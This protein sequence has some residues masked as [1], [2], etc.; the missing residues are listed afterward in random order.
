[1]EDISNLNILP[2]ISFMQF[3]PCLVYLELI[4]NVN[5]EITVC[6][7]FFWRNMKVR[8]LFFLNIFVSL[9]FTK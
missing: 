9:H 8:S 6:K 4:T 5:K 7:L 3:S 2:L 1:M